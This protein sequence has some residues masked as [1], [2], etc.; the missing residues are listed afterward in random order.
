MVMLYMVSKYLKIEKKRE[1]KK[2]F[3]SRISIRSFFFIFCLIFSAQKNALSAL[4]LPLSSYCKPWSLVRVQ[5]SCI[6]VPNGWKI[7]N[8]FWFLWLGGEKVK[9]KKK[10][11]GNWRDSSFTLRRVNVVA[12]VTFDSQVCQVCITASQKDLSYVSRLQLCL[13][14][15]DRRNTRADHET[16]HFC[17]T[18]HSHAT[19]TKIEDWNV[20]YSSFQLWLMRRW[21][22]S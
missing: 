1:K 2:K 8:T 15:K 14:M 5:W 18:F 20:S 19:A 7:T 17:K 4:P 10:T 3:G 21:A 11:L 13:W 12:R 22:L 9:E 6:A 16:H